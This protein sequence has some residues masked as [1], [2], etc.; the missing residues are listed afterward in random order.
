LFVHML[1]SPRCT[2]NRGMGKRWEVKV[3]L[4]G[5]LRLKL[6]GIHAARVISL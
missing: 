1:T 6:T 3:F 4:M 2:L 5:P